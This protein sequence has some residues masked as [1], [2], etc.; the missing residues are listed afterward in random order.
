LQGAL[1]AFRR[2]WKSTGAVADRSL[3]GF[4]K[5]LAAGAPPGT[6]DFSP[7]KDGGFPGNIGNGFILRKLMVI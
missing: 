7:V 4:R 3:D 5:S 1:G 6:V 2:G